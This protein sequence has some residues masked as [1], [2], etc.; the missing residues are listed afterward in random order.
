MAVYVVGWMSILEWCSRVKRSSVLTCTST[1]V[2]SLTDKPYDVL[3][4]S[5]RHRNTTL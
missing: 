5:D 3:I 4:V 1:L 2:F